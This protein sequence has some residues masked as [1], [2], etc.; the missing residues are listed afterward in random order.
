MTIPCVTTDVDAVRTNERPTP[1]ITVNDSEADARELR[2]VQA[3]IKERLLGLDHG[4]AT[5][6]AS[7][8]NSTTGS[9]LRAR[10]ALASGHTFQCS[11]Q[12]RVAAAAACEL[13]H[14]ASLVHDDLSDGDEHRRG[15]PSVW[16]Q[17][18]SEVA[19]CT[20]DLLLCTAFGVAADL[21]DP[22]ESSSLVRQLT[23]M[24]SRTIVGQSREVASSHQRAH[25]NFRDYLY[26]TAAKTVP[27]IE[28]P[29]ITGAVAAGA[30]ADVQSRMGRLA[31]A[32]GLAYQII[33][34][35]DDLENGV[36]GLHPFHAWHHH[37][38]PGQGGTGQRIQRA[39][40]HAQASLNR[41]R[42]T[43]GDLETRVPVSLAPRLQPLLIQLEQR[44]LAHRQNSL[45]D[46]GPA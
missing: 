29:L 45:Q 4:P 32:I 14:N 22:Q 44:A 43:L 35:L 37:C 23:T 38:P 40:L 28:L 39:T 8:Q 9:L 27:L 16:K 41:A 46:A 25:P 2:Q 33:D 20:G 24:T 21:T 36:E 17:F 42:E 6:A 5:E 19:L 26:T 11:N 13:I 15:K 31:N 18:G 3:L 1:N 10:L 12:Y 30:E 34:D 7:Y